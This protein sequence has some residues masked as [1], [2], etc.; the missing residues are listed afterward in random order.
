VDN[1]AKFVPGRY[2]FV[3]QAPGYGHRR[4]TL[5]LT[6]GQNLTFSLG[7][8][9]N[10][11]SSAKGATASGDGTAH[12][13]L[14]D[15]TENTQWTDGTA[16]AIGSQVT[17]KLSAARRITRVQVSTAGPNRFS[18]LRQFAIHTCLASAAN[19]NCTAPGSFTNIFT[20]APDAFPGA[21]WRP[22]TPDLILRSFTVPTTDA[23]HVRLV[24]VHNQCTGGPDFTGAANPDNDPLNNPDC[25]SGSTADDQA[26]ATE[27]QVFG[28][29][30]TSRPM[31]APVGG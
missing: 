17:V 5:N 1:T 2:E 31:S 4:F 10:W 9:T 20:S 11:A 29:R 15:D 13:N 25:V 28:A 24:V 7:L 26:R 23:T 18:Q 12:G 3:A 14:I 30:T 8:R 21:R 6:A 22:V 16:P 19:A 27:L